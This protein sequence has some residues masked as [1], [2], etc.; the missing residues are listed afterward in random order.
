MEALSV[1]RRGIVFA[2]LHFVSAGHNRLI[3]G[4]G[5]KVNTAFGPKDLKGLLL[6]GVLHVVLPPREDRPQ[7]HTSLPSPF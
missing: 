2:H 7:G 6:R 1:D 3:F 5:V 4:K